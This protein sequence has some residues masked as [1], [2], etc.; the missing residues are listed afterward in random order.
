MD[1]AQENSFDWICFFFFFFL[2]PVPTL[3]ISLVLRS[4]SGP[5]SSS[6][7]HLKIVRRPA[8]HH[9]L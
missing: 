6:A 3:V 2:N 1:Y 7:P 4:S 9:V 8:C 5:Q